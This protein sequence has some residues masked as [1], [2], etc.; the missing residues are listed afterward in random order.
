M[1]V[2]VKG[3]S[4]WAQWECVIFTSNSH[5]REWWKDCKWPIPEHS[6]RGFYRRFQRIKHKIAT[7]P[8]KHT[9]WVKEEVE[10]IDPEYKV[11]PKPKNIPEMFETAPTD[12]FEFGEPIYAPMRVPQ[13]IPEPEEVLTAEQASQQ[14]LSIY[15]QRRSQTKL[16]PRFRR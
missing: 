6:W 16:Q 11:V 1:Q 15:K 12:A 2:E 7:E 3:G 8:N 14:A 4:V 13:P 5:P 10:Y 9:D